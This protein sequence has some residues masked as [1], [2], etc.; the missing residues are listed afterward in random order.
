MPLH[1]EFIYPRSTRRNLALAMASSSSV[2]VSL[3]LWYTAGVVLHW[4]EQRYWSRGSR[5]FPQKSTNFTCS[6]LEVK[7]TPERKNYH[8]QTCINL[9]K[10]FQ[11][12]KNLYNTGKKNCLQIWNI[13]KKLPLHLELTHLWAE[14]RYFRKLLGRS[15]LLYLT[16]SILTTLPESSNKVG[17]S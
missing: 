16:F 15:S 11:C 12:L 4:G 5:Y 13:E 9:V 3:L 10:I 6:T 7:Y 2:S 17:G 8:C 14:L 1:W